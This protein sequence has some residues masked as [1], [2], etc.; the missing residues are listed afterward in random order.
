MLSNVNSMAGNYWHQHLVAAAATS[1][2]QIA[3]SL[4][5]ERVFWNPCDV[6]VDGRYR[7]AALASGPAARLSGPAP[8]S[9]GEKLYYSGVYLFR[10]FLVH[11]VARAGDDYFFQAAGEELVHRFAFE[12]VQSL[13]AVSCAV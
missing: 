3:Q 9:S 5:P 1:K 11:E 13:R 10:L 8:R 2:R 12:S 7:T 6:K 4:T